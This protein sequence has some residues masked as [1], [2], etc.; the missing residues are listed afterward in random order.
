[1]ANNELYH[2]VPPPNYSKCLDYNYSYLFG[3]DVNSSPNEKWEKGRSGMIEGRGFY[4]DYSIKISIN[5]RSAE[6][7]LLFSKCHLRV[8]R[9]S[10]Y[11]IFNFKRCRLTK[12]NVR[13]FYHILECNYQN[14]FRIDKN[15]TRLFHVREINNIFNI[16][17]YRNKLFGGVGYFLT[18]Y[19][20]DKYFNCSFFFDPP[21]YK[22]QIPETTFSPIHK[23]IFIDTETSGLEPGFNTILQLSYQIVSIGSWK[24]L[25]KVNHY[26]QWPKDERRVDGRAIVVNNL[27]PH[28]IEKQGESDKRNALLELIEDLA[29]CQLVIGHNINFDIGFIEADAKEEGIK[30]TIN[31]P[32]RID[33]MKDTTELCQLF[34]RKLGEYKWPTLEELAYELKINCK[35]LS[36]HDSQVDVDITRKCFKKLYQ[37][38]FYEFRI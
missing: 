18:T 9:E 36:M 27:W 34:P 15:F 5:K 30:G 12:E 3:I 6:N 22:P 20:N 13:D 21:I 24:T 35:D 16:N 38:G 17:D 19:P 8:F 26:F 11:K 37:N 4:D 14:N 23:I 31:W 7:P 32:F 2:P 1:M 29:S 10:Q 28:Y 25:K 33:T